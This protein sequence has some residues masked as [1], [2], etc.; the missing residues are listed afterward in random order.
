MIPL[1]TTAT[2]PA[3][4]RCGWAFSSL[5]APWVAQRVCAMPVVPANRLGSRSSSSRTRPLAL[6][7]LMAPDRPLTATPAE[8]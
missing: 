8:S 7:V 3:A 6:T 2:W 1:C 5:G 4:S